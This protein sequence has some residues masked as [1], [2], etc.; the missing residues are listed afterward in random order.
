MKKQ[1]GFSTALFLMIGGF[2]I[3]AAQTGN[4]AN[5]AYRTI[6]HLTAKYPERDYPFTQTQYIIFEVP[7]PGVL[8]VVV[9]YDRA[10][11]NPNYIWHYHE[12]RASDPTPPP[13]SYNGHLQDILPHTRALA[14]Y[15]TPESAVPL[16]PIT[17]TRYYEVDK[18]RA[19]LEIPPIAD[20][21]QNHQYALLADAKISFSN[22]LAAT[23]ETFKEDKAAPVPVGPTDPVSPGPLAPEIGPVLTVAEVGFWK[24]TWTRRPGTNIFDASWRNPS[25]QTATDVVEITG[26][27]G[28]T[29]TFRRKGNGG[30]YSGTLSPDGSSINGTAS[31]YKPGQQWTATISPQSTSPSDAADVI[32]EWR[33][34][35]GGIVGSADENRPF[36]PG[37]LVIER[38]GS[39]LAAKV[40]FDA[41]ARWEA[42]NNVAFERGELRFDRS[43]PAPG[44]QAVQHYSARISAGRLNGT[45]SQGNITQ[46]WWGGQNR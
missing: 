31:W 33:I 9:Y 36:F 24:G 44:G 13:A 14:S 6:S 26:V 17:W 32:G 29:I 11:V 25:G 15:A 35:S 40:N 18:G 28:R 19:L 2:W 42:L 39:G 12:V 16:K 41:Y 45:F 7:G 27:S 8:K 4:V 3:A 46:R 23:G 30:T 38:S 21:G 43:V 10:P 1:I 5:R 22:G 20:Y 37:T 34:F